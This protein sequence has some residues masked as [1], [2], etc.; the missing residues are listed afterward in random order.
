MEEEKDPEQTKQDLID[1]IAQVCVS[2][3]VN[4]CVLEFLS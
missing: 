4:I 1:K 2:V 3:Y